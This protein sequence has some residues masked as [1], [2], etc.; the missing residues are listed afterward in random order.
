[1]PY[2]YIGNPFNKVTQ[3]KEWKDWRAYQRAT[4]DLKSGK[5]ASMI[6][7]ADAIRNFKSPYRNSDIKK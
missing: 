5:H 4:Q 1:M 7:I 3:N 6:Q 2:D